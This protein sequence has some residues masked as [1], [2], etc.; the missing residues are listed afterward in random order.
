MI[1]EDIPVLHA[2]GDSLAEAWENAMLSLFYLGSEMPTEYDQDDHPP[3]IDATMVITV[4]RPFHEPMIHMDMPGGF[5]DLQE[6]TMEV[7]D[8]IKDH[9]MYRYDPHG[10]IWKYTYNERLRSYETINDYIDQIEDMCQRLFKT[11]HTRRAQAITWIPAVDIECNDPP[12]LQSIWCRL[13]PYKDYWKLNTNLRIRSN[14]AYKAAFMNMFAFTFLQKR[15]AD[16]ITELGRPTVVGR[17]CHIADSFHL[18]GKDIAEFEGRFL[19]AYTQRLFDKRTVKYADVKGM[20]LESI[21]TI[22]KKV[23]LTTERQQRVEE[24]WNK[25][26]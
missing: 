4:K 19:K 5:E 16:R 20:M 26:D 14:D 15:I 24:A 6:Y 13:T 9:W 7:C 3:S 18:Y 17:Y 1:T 23:G 10:T 2:E 25:N 8:G 12:C 21:P 22:C 11:P